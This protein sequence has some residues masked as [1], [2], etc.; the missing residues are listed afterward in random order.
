MALPPFYNLLVFSV[1]PLKENCANTQRPSKSVAVVATWH[2]VCQNDFGTLLS[3]DAIYR[4][5][6]NDNLKKINPLVK[7]IY[8]RMQLSMPSLKLLLERF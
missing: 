6:E 5:N 8:F 2:L 1:A 7:C 3:V 4:S